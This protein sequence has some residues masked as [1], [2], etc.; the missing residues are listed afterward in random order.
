MKRPQLKRPKRPTLRRSG[1]GPKPAKKRLRSP[2]SFSLRRSPKKPAP[3]KGAKPKKTKKDPADDLWFRLSTRVRAVGYWIREKAQAAGKRLG[4]AGEWVADLWLKRSRE[5]RIRIVA[6]AGVLALYAVVKFAPVPGVPCQISAAK[7]CA[8]P[9]DTIALAPADT[10]LYAH[11]TID[12]DTAQFERA[13]DAFEQLSDLRTILG[14]EIPAALPTPSGTELNIAEDILPWADQDLAVNLLPGPKG[15]A[16]PVFVV[17]VGDRE[18][19]DQ[20]LT[21]IAPTGVQ[22]QSQQQGE[23]ALS[24]YTPGFASAFVD[25]ELVFGSEAGVR[26]VLDVSAGTVDRLEDAPQ[27]A[28]RD[29]LPDAR[30][31]EVYLSQPGVQQLLANRTGAATQLETFVDYGAAQAVAAGLIARPD[32]LEVALVSELDPKL[33]EGSPSFFSALPDFEPSLADEAGERTIGYVG[34]GDLGPTATGVLDQGGKGAQGLAASLQALAGTLEQ[35]AGVN[36][37]RDLLPAL[38]GQ[39]A[40]VAEP[41]DGVPFASLIVDGVDEEQA[42]PAL[43]GLQ[44][45]LLEALQPAGG[46][47]VPR[48]EETEVDGVKVQS[49]QASATVNLSYALFD[50]KLVISTDPA[51][52]A[53]VK[54]DSDNLAD[55]GAY[56]KA[57]DDLPDEV[58]ALVFLNLDE[59]FGQ[60]RDRTDLAEDPFF[61]N[62]SVLFENASSLGLAVNGSDE[63]IRTELFLALD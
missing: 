26:R 59:L 28:P 7:E 37:L 39:A 46:A 52:V 16:L 4:A 8:P 21:T 12:E 54:A 55:S 17:G 38:G 29:E 45:P 24:V 57:T 51:G 42:A 9:N 6:V 36:P 15:T 33:I 1:K 2:R 53:Q 58:S 13:T 40:L 35:E 34:V 32:G 27:N 30:F 18:G 43:A 48:F 62:L 25:D 23:A 22:P 5:G 60:I 31:A 47:Q 10:L 11:V 41:T 50:G 14:A 63:R 56:E 20:F 3:P 49:V 61:A 44:K 19:A